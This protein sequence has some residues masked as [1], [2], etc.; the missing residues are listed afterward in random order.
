MSDPATQNR[1]L[2][3]ST[4]D[5]SEDARADSKPDPASAPQRPGDATG[6]PVVGIG[7]S[8]GGLNALSEFLRALPSDTGMAFVVVQH[9]SATYPSN[10]SALLQGTTR[11]PV[12]EAL[13][14]LVVRPD[15][16]YVITPNTDLAIVGDI[17]HVTPRGDG[18][19]VHHSVDHFQRSLAAQKHR[20]Q[21]GVILSGSGSDGTLGIAAIKAAGGITFAHDDS[22]EHSAMPMNA[23]SHGCVDFVL[24]P[25]EIARALAKIARDGFPKPTP[26]DGG[27]VAGAADGSADGSADG[28]AAL[29]NDPASYVRIIAALQALS[30]VDFTHYRPTTIQRR[31]SRRMGVLFL[32]TLA[33]YADHLEKH[34]EESAGLL[35][36]ILIGVTSFYRDREVFDALAATVI[37]QLFKDRSA[38]EPIRAWVIGC[39]TGQEPYSL[40]IEL[41]EQLPA[42]TPRPVIQIF[43]TDIS[44]WSLAKARAGWYPDS[45]MADVPADRLRRWFTKDGA[46]YR[47]ARSVRDLCVFAKHDITEGIPFGRMDLITCRNVLIYLGE[48]LQ[49][50]VFPTIYVALKPRGILM[51]GSSE[52]VGR[53]ANLFEP[54]DER[55]RIYRKGATPVGMTLTSVP[56][57]QPRPDLS[58]AGPPLS[59]SMP[60]QQRAAD[61]IVLSRFSPAGVLVDGA[62]GVV[63][64]RG[65]TSPFLEPSP[66]NP[67]TN[68]LTMVPFAVAEALRSAMN[69]AKQ[70]IVSVRCERVLHRRKDVVREIAFEVVPVL[71]PPDPAQT[72]LVLFQEVEP[73]A[74]P[75]SVN[76]AGTSASAHG[77]GDPVALAREV[78]QLRNEIAASTDHNQAL[79]EQVGD[80]SD[81]LKESQEESS[82]STEEFRS[83]NEELQ[84]TK[85]EIEST[86]EEL[87]T[88]NEE[89]RSANRELAKAS[90]ALAE[91]GRLTGAIVETMRTPLLVLDG[92][93]RVVLANQAFLGE[94]KVTL[95]A[96]RGRLVYELGNGQWDIPELRRLLEEVMPTNSAFDDFEVT[97]DFAAIGRRIMLLNARRLQVTGIQSHQIVLGIADIT[98]RT[99]TLQDL[100]DTSAELQRSNAELDQF[101]AVASHDLQ[102][103]L[104]MITSFLSL[105]ERHYRAGI[106]ERGRGYLDHASGAA[107]RLSEMITAILAFSRVGQCELGFVST[108]SAVALRDALE[109]LKL[110]I[111]AVS[112]SITVGP[113]PQVCANPAQLTQ[114]FQNLVG[115][116]L[117]Y[118]S[119]QRPPAIRISAEVSVGEATFTIADNGIGMAEKDF[120][121]AFKI[122]QR[123]D[124][125]NTHTGSGIGLATCKKI[126]ERHGGRIW[127]ESTLDVGT[128][129]FFTVPR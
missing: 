13:D 75:L 118:I 20:R 40:A 37:P 31:M 1:G 47:I 107:R 105:Y 92:D 10:L 106:D 103:P 45:V 54:L 14:G 8:A 120:T 108:D 23:I 99:R 68:L 85:E 48:V 87:I 36:D 96:T 25:A 114:L 117:T 112:A 63:Q 128:T 98:E 115:N 51:L 60:D 101:A 91:Q 129:F 22:A 9:L 123:L 39:A 93:L 65:R 104:R 80:L 17:L 83:T 58:D 49:R 41:L 126:V 109:N 110:K 12:V 70:H 50:K 53:F 94:F 34:V 15:H 76:A 28:G 2:P 84:S 116:A 97:H 77:V 121:R 113:L 32:T 42:A 11:L 64:Y 71:I 43:A 124:P 18:S 4:G 33:E 19:H 35:K 72:F 44:D 26:C 86:N 79:R 16:V 3:T 59:T 66:G 78:K 122:F 89:L 52:T 7:A 27:D 111:T 81:Q 56:M 38:D 67:S 73:T 6:F 90:N 61:R 62:M 69:E 100:K 29:M 24:A 95:E 88:I 119:D 127:I 74:A 5:F 57:R 21:V 30:G 102:E 125:A 46:G 55:N 82:S